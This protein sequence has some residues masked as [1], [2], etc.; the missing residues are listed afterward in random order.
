MRFRILAVL[1]CASTL[2]Q[3]QSGPIID[4]RPEDMLKSM[5]AASGWSPANLPADAVVNATVTL[6][7]L[8]APPPKTL[9]FKARG[10][11]QFRWEYIGDGRVTVADL[12]SGRVT[13]RIGIPS[14]AQ[15]GQPWLLP[16]LGRIQDFVSSPTNLVYLGKETLSEST[17]KIVVRP[18]SS[19][20][21]ARS[22]EVAMGMPTTIW[23][24]AK[25]LLPVQ[26]EYFAQSFTNRLAFMKR[27]RKY[28]GYKQVG[29]LL[30]PFQQEV[31]SG[32]QK[33]YSVEIQDVRFNVG[34]SS[35]EFENTS[36]AGGQ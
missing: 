23:L 17:Y 25:T 12:S 32:N 2:A 14:A 21:S 24:S 3:S 34:V 8:D 15:N 13:N 31:W 5:M 28:G 1:L 7:G 20:S 6:S 11:T 30:V 18:S 19:Q 10:R 36:V 16:F 26:I 4:Q 22:D 35:A 9:I 29:S 33:L 27:T